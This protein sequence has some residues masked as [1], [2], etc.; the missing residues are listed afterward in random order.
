MYLVDWEYAGMNDPMWD[1][2]DVSIEAEMN[3]VMDKKL[4][5]RYLG[6]EPLKDEIFRFQANKI[7]IDFLWSL[8][9]K[10]RVPFEGTAMEQYA[11]DRYNRLKQNLL[12][13]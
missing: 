2:A 8:W 1:L 11:M 6:Q 3:E 13:I 4:I 7:Y 12:S 10:T 5:T 9:G